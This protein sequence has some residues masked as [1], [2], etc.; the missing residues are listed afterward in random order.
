MSFRGLKDFWD[1]CHQMDGQHNND[2]VKTNFDILLGSK[3]WGEKKRNMLFIPE[4]QDDFFCFIPRNL[5]AKYELACSR[6]SDSRVRRKSKRSKKRNKGERGGGRGRGEGT[7]F[8][9]TPYPTPSLFFFFPAHI[10]L[11]SRHDLNAWNRLSMNFNKSKL[12]H[13]KNTELKSCVKKAYAHSL[14]KF[15]MHVTG[16]KRISIPL[17]YYSHTKILVIE[18]GKIFQ[19]SVD[20]AS[21]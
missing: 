13:R 19:G 1:H 14:C 21:F 9:L 18:N 11:P 16:C 8:A 17:C 6:H 15:F 2:W 5:A 7:S 12:V 4:P 3:T 20:S 10:S